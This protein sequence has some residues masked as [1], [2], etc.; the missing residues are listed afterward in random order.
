MGATRRRGFTL[1]EALAAAVLVAIVLP[2][3]MHGFSLGTSLSA[4]ARRKAEAATL[5]HSVLTEL[6]LTKDWQRGV[7]SGDFENDH[8]DYRWEAEL[9]EWNTS[10]MKELNVHVIWQAQGTEHALILST[11]VDAEGE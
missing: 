2:V 10:A 8:P 5:G 1:V 3:I 11:L 9:R 6:A 7:L 4:A